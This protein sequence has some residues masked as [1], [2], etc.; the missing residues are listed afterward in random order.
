MNKKNN[1][2]VSTVEYLVMISAVTLTVIIFTVPNG[3]F[4]G[5]LNQALVSPAD[6]MVIM[7][8]SIFF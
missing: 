3:F 1:I 4:S 8:N 2:G 7:T 6:K 5:S